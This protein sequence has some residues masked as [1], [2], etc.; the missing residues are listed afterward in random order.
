MSNL[1]LHALMSH[2]E[3]VSRLLDSPKPFI[4]KVS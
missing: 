1:P 2:E 3:T 4:A